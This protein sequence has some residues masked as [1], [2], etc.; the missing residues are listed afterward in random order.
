MNNNI[1]DEELQYLRDSLMAQNNILED[2]AGEKQ[3]LEEFGKAMMNI[4]EDFNEEKNRVSEYNNELRNEIEERLRTEQQLKMV[5]KELEGF[6]YSISHDLRAPLRAIQGYSR[7]LHEQYSHKLDDEGRELLKDILRNSENMGQLIDDILHFSR[8]SRKETHYTHIN[9][10]DLFLRTY[11]DL[12]LKDTNSNLVCNIH[13]LPAAYADP[14]LIKQV[15]IN[16]L[17]NAIKYSS[18]RENPYIE[19]SGESGNEENIYKITDNGV[20]FDMKYKDKLFGVFQ[21]LHKVDEFE[22]T[23]VG[24]AIVNRIIEK[25]KGRVWAEGVI[26]KG[27]A[28]Y[29]TLPRK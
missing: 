14:V 13:A 3:M 19:V 29:F 7:I 12:Y 9:M 11:H 20:G 26:N 17:S 8:L 4:L 5:N 25:H 21:R 28:F 2:I 27:A 24:L 6:S 1:S 18:K 15:V 16:L 22:G 10:T 23:G